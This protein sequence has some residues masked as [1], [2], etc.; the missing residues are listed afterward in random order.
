MTMHAIQQRLYGGPHAVRWRPC[1]VE[2]IAAHF[3]VSDRELAALPPPPQAR[4]VLP[5]SVGKAPGDQKPISFTISTASVDRG[6]DTIDPNGWRL[7]EYRNN[8]LVLWGHDTSSLPIGSGRAWLDGGKLKGSVSFAQTDKAQ[9]IRGLVQEG[10]IRATS[11]GF[12]PLA[13]SWATEKGR[14]VGAINFHTQELLEFSLVTIPANAECLVD[15]ATI[16][17]IRQETL[18]RLKAPIRAE[19]ERKAACIRRLNDIAGLERGRTP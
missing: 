4:D 12:I 11:V 6:G 2:R 8:P 3:G 16:K 10:K 19:E 14:G 5:V 17:S 18:D 7:A 15:G 1:D 9:E 13:W